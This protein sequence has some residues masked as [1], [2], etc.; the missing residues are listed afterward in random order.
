MAALKYGQSNHL[1][2]D[3]GDLPGAETVC[4]QSLEL[5]ERAGDQAGSLMV[6]LERAWIVGAAG[7]LPGQAREA[8]VRIPMIP[9]T[10]SGVFGHRGVKRR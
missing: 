10:R 3:V 2:S 5:S 7:D 6:A 8:Q 9:N 4:R 1:T